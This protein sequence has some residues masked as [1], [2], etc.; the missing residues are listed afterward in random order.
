ME[1]QRLRVLAQIGL[2]K[3]RG[4]AAFE[5]Y[6]QMMFPWK[7]VSKK[8]EGAAAQAAL[9]AWAKQGPL[10][11]SPVFADNR[12]RSQLANRMREVDTAREKTVTSAL[13]RFNEVIPTGGRDRGRR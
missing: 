7:E 1:H 9:A 10:V 8:Q 5:E 11:I 6:M 4:G 2:D 12:V 13:R 3:T